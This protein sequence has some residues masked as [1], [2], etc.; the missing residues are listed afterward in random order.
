MM[1]LVIACIA[2]AAI[3]ACS[4]DS[5]LPTATGKGSVMALNAISTSPEIGFLIE[6]RGIAKT[7][8]ERWEREDV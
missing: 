2:A 8:A 4:S 7:G 1:R 5:S 3:S 6:E